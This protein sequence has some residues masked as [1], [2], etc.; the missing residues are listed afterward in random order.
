MNEGM[1]NSLHMEYKH[2]FRVEFQKL[3]EQQTFAQVIFRNCE[4]LFGNESAPYHHTLLHCF[5]CSFEGMALGLSRIWDEKKR[6]VNLISIPNLINEFK[7]HNFLG[8]RDLAPGGEGR[9]TF[10]SL[11]DDPLRMRLRV[12]RTEALAHSIM[13]GESG[14]R[15]K[16]NVKEKL[17]F[18]LVNRDV[19]C[20]CRKT[21]ELLFSL[22]DQLSVSAWRQK[23]LADMTNEV[24]QRHVVFLKHFMAEVK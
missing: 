14:D 22:N 10:D 11:Y 15:K 21:L 2:R 20:Y 13:I 19:V 5:G 4:L 9:K 17:E 16:S 7:D 6:D 12:A 23:S 1:L 3:L 8:C 24:T 18:G